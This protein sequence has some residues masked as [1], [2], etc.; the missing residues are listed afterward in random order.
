M[1]S[2]AWRTHCSNVERWKNT[3]E[4]I[5]IHLQ[6]KNLNLLPTLKAVSCLDGW[7][8]WKS[9][10]RFSFFSVTLFHFFSL[11]LFYLVFF[12]LSFFL[13][14][15]SL[16][17]SPNTEEFLLWTLQYG[18]KWKAPDFHRRFQCASHL[19]IYQTCS[20]PTIQTSSLSLLYQ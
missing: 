14:F 12:F 6:Q 8:F 18:T 11:V 20:L 3:E 7:I 17:L 13:A 1:Y 10:F 9:Y 15:F 5:T 16:F 4:I 19:F 2:Y